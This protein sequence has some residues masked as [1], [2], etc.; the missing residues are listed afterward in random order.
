MFVTVVFMWSTNPLLSLG[1]RVS[2]FLGNRFGAFGVTVVLLAPATA[3]AQTAALP[4]SADF[5]GTTGY[6]HTSDNVDALPSSLDGPNWT[7]GFDQTPSSDSTENTFGADGSA[8]SSSDFGGPAYFE[9]D[10]IDVSAVS[11]VNVSGE[12]DTVGSDVF[13]GSSEQFQWSYTLDGGSP[14]TGPAITSDGSLDTPGGWRTIDVSEASTMRI[15]FEFNV[16]GSGDG[17]SI[18]SLQVSETSGNTITLALSD[19]AI[20]ESGSGATTATL[21]VILSSPAPAGGVDVDLSSSDETEATVSPA[22]ITISEG[23]TMG[24][25]TVSAVSDGEFDGDST[26][27][28]SAS[29][30]DG[31]DADSVDLIVQ[32]TDPFPPDDTT[33][34]QTIEITS[35]GTAGT[36]EFYA[37]SDDPL[38]NRYSLAEFRVSPGDLGVAIVESLDELSLLLTINDRSFSGSGEFD[39]LFTPDS[40]ADLSGYSEMAY[41][42]DEPDGINDADFTNAP[43]KIGSGVYPFD[44]GVGGGNDFALTLSPDA[45]ASAAIVSEINN[46]SAFHLIIATTGTARPTFSGVGNTFDPGDPGLSIEVTEGTPQ[47]EPENHPTGFSVNAEGAQLEFSWTDATG[48][49][50]PNGYVIQVEDQ[51]DNFGTLEDGTPVAEDLDLSDGSAVI[52][53]GASVESASL[54]TTVDG[55]YYARIIPFSNSG[56]AINYKTDETIQ[57]GDATISGVIA[58]EDFEGESASWENRTQIGEDDGWSTDTGEAFINAFTGADSYNEN[59]Y[60]VSPELDFSGF[61]AATISFRYAD[62][63]NGPDLKLVYSLDYTGSGAPEDNGTWSEVAYTFEDTSTGSGSNY[64]TENDLPLPSALNDR[65]GVYLA[66]QY[67]A[68]GPDAEAWRVDDVEVLA[69][70]AAPDPVPTN[71]ASGLEAT[72]S[73]ATIDLVW[74]DAT[75]GPGEQLPDGYLVLA[76]ETDD[77]SS[78]VNG[79]DPEEDLDLSDGSAVAKV[80]QGEEFFA[81]SGLDSE[82]TYYFELYPFTNSGSDILYKTDETV[83]SASAATAAIIGSE[84]FEGT[85]TWVNAQANG[86]VGW[87]IGGGHAEAD[88]FIGAVGVSQIAYLV[89]ENAF[90]LSD[91]ENLVLSFVTQEAQDGSQ[92]ELRYSTDYSG[93]GDPEENGT[94]KTIDGVDFNDESTNADFSERTPNSVN[95]PAELESE[96]AV[97][98]AFKYSATGGDPLD[99]EIWRVDDIVLTGDTVGGPGSDPVGDWLVS[100]GLPTDADL[101]S[102]AGDNDG[103]PLIIEYLV[104]GDPNA[105]E[106]SPFRATLG[107]VEVDLGDGPEVF[108]NVL[109]LDY[110]RPSD[111]KAEG[112]DVELL[113]SDDLSTFDP[114]DFGETQPAEIGDTGVFVHGF[115]QQTSGGEPM[116]ISDPEAKEFLRLRVTESSE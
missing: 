55:T 103:Q 76:S 36:A 48:G 69:D 20:S 77:I 40:A 1:F 31:F 99:A 26:V 62:N 109:I 67:T 115:Y 72:A 57:A 116:P 41:D 114:V 10:P 94:W 34:L 83:P 38:F 91:K 100:N 17:F 101:S 47:D 43:V 86:T 51:P 106:G 39:I 111:Q 45:A 79:V 4:Y 9:T 54:T 50:V 104:D 53:V 46:N 71:H 6:S 44:G 8:L 74:S 5:T 24:V 37:Q 52:T 90:D 73:G 61:E 75:A 14:V 22:S 59:H 21:S 82:T 85:S 28:I 56:A 35:G 16:N 92:L 49:I 3:S 11:M 88:G 89:N 25:A 13:N 87:V 60:L 12:G 2:R 112:L 63:F 96:G 78:P 27:T 64:T 19:T 93:T 30:P 102:D 42:G 97:F 29:S 105:P 70:T 65:S 95:L 33:A 98:L 110:L 15:R 23:G 81:F 66:F 84:D 68:T 113:G 107:E 7:I 80:S 58:F 108:E 32:N 18:S